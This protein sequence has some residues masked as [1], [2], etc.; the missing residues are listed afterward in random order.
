VTDGLNAKI[1]WITYSS[2]GFRNRDRFKLVIYFQ[3]SGLD[4]NP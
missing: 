2:R 1:Q 3:C 4:L